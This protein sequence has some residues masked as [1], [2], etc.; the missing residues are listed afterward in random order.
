MKTNKEVLDGYEKKIVD[1]SRRNRLLKYP[2]KAKRIVFDVSLDEFVDKYGTIDEFKIEFLH[3]QILR[4]DL[5]SSD[6]DADNIESSHLIVDDPESSEDIPKTKPSGEKLITV[7][8]SLRLDTKRKFEEHGLHTLFLTIGRAQWKEPVSGFRNSGNAKKD[9]FDYNAPILLI[10]IKIEE[11][12]NPKRT[13]VETYLEYNDITV[14]KVLCLLFEKQYGSKSIEFDNENFSDLSGLMNGLASQLKE[15]FDELKIDHS[16]SLDIEI[17]QYSFYGQQIYEDISRNEEQMLGNNFINALCTHEQIYQDNVQIDIEN[18]DG[19]LTAYDDFN[20]MDADTSQLSVIQKAIIGNHLNVQG[21]PG[22]GK[23]QTIVNLISNLLARNKTVLLV[24]E[25]QVALEVVLG[26][27]KEVGLD[28]LCLP[29]FHYNADKRSFAK[30]VIADRDSLAQQPFGAVELDSPLHYR[31]AKISKLREY[32]HAL[33]EVAPLLGKRIHWIHGELAKNQNLNLSDSASVPWTGPDP[34]ATTFDEYSNISS[35]LDSMASVYNVRL[36]EEHRHWSEMNRSNFSPDFVA[37]INQIL[38]LIKDLSLKIPDENSQFTPQTIDELREYINCEEPICLI[39]SLQGRLREKAG[40]V[41][42]HS[43]LEQAMDIVMLY[44][45]RYNQCKYNYGI[46]TKWQNGTLKDVKWIIKDDVPLSNLQSAYKYSQAVNTLI[47]DLIQKISLIKK[48]KYLLEIPLSQLINLKAPVLTN[49]IIQSLK[50]WDQLSG[51]EAMLEQ[52]NN[53]NLLYNHIKEAKKTLD[54]WAIIVS[55]LENKHPLLMTERFG[56]KYRTIFR[57]FSPQYKKD[58]AVIKDWC[59]VSKPKKHSEFK[60][61]SLAVSSWISLQDKLNGLLDN[62]NKEFLVEKSDELTRDTAIIAC[63]EVNNLISWLHSSGLN[64]IPEDLSTLMRNNNDNVQTINVLFDKVESLLGL[65]MSQWSV[66]ELEKEFNGLSLKDICDLL[67]SLQNNVNSFFKM[68]GAVK[69][70]Q[71]SW[72]DDISFNDLKFRAEEIDKLSS[73]FK[74][75]DDLNLISIID[76]NNI[77]VNIINNHDY[78]ADLLADIRNLK[79]CLFNLPWPVDVGINVSDS[80]TIV[81]HLTKELS[82]WKAIICDYEGYVS[83]LNKLFDSDRSLAC[84]ESLPWSQFVKNIKLML[85]DSEG[86]EK[87]M[88]YK[89]YSSRISESGHSWFLRDTEKKAIANPRAAFAESL[90]SA[91]LEIYY[92]NEPALRDFDVKDHSKLIK[93]FQKLE[94]DVLRVNTQRILQLKS[95]EIRTAKRMGG[96]QDRELVR[97]SQLQKRHK[98]IR[99]VVSICSEQLIKYKPCWM[100]SPLTLSSY[101]PYGSLNFDTVIF[102]EASQMRVEHA[103]GSIARAKQVI[104]FGDHNQLPPT[105]FFEVI[106]DGAEEDEDENNNDYESILHA[107]KEI[108]PGADKLLSNHY[109]SKYE[110]LIAFS[111][112]HI[113]D[114][115]LIT[116]PNPSANYKAVQFE[117]VNNGIFDSGAT[118]R[119]NTEAKRVVELCIRQITEE[120]A[121][122]LGV[123][124]FS[125][126]QEVAIRDAL[127]DAIKSDSELQKYLDETSDKS[128]PFFIKNLESVQGDERDVIILSVGYGRDKNGNIYNRFGPINGQNGYRRLNVAITRAIEKVICVSSLHASD[129]Q[130]SE[131]ASKGAKLLQKYIEYAEVGVCTL[132]NYRQASENKNAEPDSPFELEVQRALENKGCVVHRQIGVSGFKIDLGILNPNNLEEYILGIECDGATYHSS[133]SARMNDRIRQEI[134]ERLGWKIYRVWSQ[135]WLTHKDDII[136]DIIRNIN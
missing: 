55:D 112:H 31:E 116:F 101:I 26:R 51:L 77:N 54:K 46:P 33:S 69:E 95:P 61:V 27:L 111:N 130:L 97:Q 11:R 41:D 129:I 36:I 104:I 13:V 57:E 24:C 52:L 134:L 106:G 29:L 136:E 108:L 14:N 68:F 1:L 123:I 72:S 22:T 20:V 76:D 119:N 128:H 67:P 124:A 50:S 7:L 132:E 62:F 96:G 102:D 120:P 133:Y 58:C 17:G 30:K 118:H 25:K 70:I 79:N 35:L 100:M 65:L 87:W 73:E 93:E 127:L 3:K 48:G 90:W 12:K 88:S 8:N 86:L 39:N 18:P 105:S 15:I 117:Y 5:E 125:R 44:K 63:K 113:Y 6:V 74:K 66:F 83:E 84:L 121:K 78:L 34:L 99:K 47:L 94:E 98:P 60:E 131:D 91:W 82:K 92:K 85:L 81:K 9:E 115:K 53:V 71:S 135:H 56:Q 38:E 103:L 64:I 80:E 43:A 49:P 89:K 45:Q 109:R 4:Q 40:L 126:S 23:S 21:P 32:A 10:P 114:D 110:D 2:F 19:L 16:I 59:N 37:R 122:S 28:R 75:L 107:T 42:S